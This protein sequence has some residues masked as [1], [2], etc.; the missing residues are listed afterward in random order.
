M[1]LH[2]LHH[3]IILVTAL[4]GAEARAQWLDVL[5]SDRLYAGPN[6]VAWLAGDMDGDGRTDILHPWNNNGALGLNVYRS[7]GTSYVQVFG[8]GN[9]GQGSPALAWLAGDMD[10]DG[11]TDIFQ[12]WNNNGALGLNVYRS[13]GTGYVTA[14][15]SGNMG[16]GYGAVAWLTGDVD[17]D[18]RTDLIQ[19]WSNRGT[20]G[21]NVFRST[22]T[23][24]SLMFSSSNMGQGAT[25]LAWLTGDMDGDG[26]TDIFQPWNNNGTLGLNVYRSTGTGY[27][28]AFANGNMGQGS[29]ALAWLVGDMD[30]DGRT[31]ILQPWNNNGTL[32]LIAYR[33][34]GTGYVQG[35]ASNNMGRS[36]SAVS[37]QAADIDGDGRTDLF[38]PWS[39]GGHVGL[40]VY[41]STG[42]G[43]SL[44]YFGDNFGQLSSVGWLVGSFD[45]GKRQTLLHLWSNNGVLA[46]VVYGLRFLV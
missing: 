23:G 14:F 36:S 6:S 31:D 9:M 11:R 43:Y 44:G 22:G 40:N 5:W 13:T 39:N 35:F 42:T 29:N 25:G 4:A 2:R 33:S 41:V 26:R 28:T 46:L 8:S 19:P 45:G 16:A 34:T 27:V 3:L 21:L 18:G 12:P 37:W 30:G 24:Y 1:N 17:G 15:G 38:Q 10:G 20:L 7:T 32:G